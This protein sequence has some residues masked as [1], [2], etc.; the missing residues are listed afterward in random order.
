MR[1]NGAFPYTKIILSEPICL[2]SFVNKERLQSDL[3]IQNKL[4][5]ALT[6]LKEK[7]LD[8]LAQLQV[9][10][11]SIDF[12]P[13]SQ[14]Q[15]NDLK[16]QRGIDSLGFAFDRAHLDH[17]GRKILQMMNT[18]LNKRFTIFFSPFAKQL[19]MIL[20]HELGHIYQYMNNH[21]LK[22]LI[23][24]SMSSIKDLSTMSPELLG[25]KYA[26]SA[27][28]YE[29]ALNLTFAWIYNN[30]KGLTA[31]EVEE[32]SAYIIEHNHIL[33]FFAK[34]LMLKKEKEINMPLLGLSK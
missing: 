8:S 19:N 33:P 15:L 18:N 11:P 6:R 29:N 3:T 24:T 14:I 23:D 32:N 22:I 30:D 9:L 21:E 4:L 2:T 7:P 31:V 5:E 1:I 12:R 20:M 13:L 10:E 34:L 16:K 26:F 28:E 27:L 25:S 17:N